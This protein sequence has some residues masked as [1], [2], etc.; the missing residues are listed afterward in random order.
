MRAARKTTITAAPYG[1]DG[2]LLH[3]EGDGRKFLHRADPVTGEVLS[4]EQ[5]F[6]TVPT[7]PPTFDHYTGQ[8]NTTRKQIRDWVPVYTEIDWRP[9]DP[10]HATFAIDSMRSG[11]SAKYLILTSV[12][13]PGDNRTFPMFISDLID[14]LVRSGAERRAILSGRWMVS[15]R[16]ANYGLRL[17][18]EDE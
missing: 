17:A 2:S 16:G 6:E 8:R 4:D 11:R 12:E 1:Q 13:S 15:K 5:I 10:F 9:N 7:W 3:Y 14:V 18:K